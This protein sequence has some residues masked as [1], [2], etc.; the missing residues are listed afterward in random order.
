MITILGSFELFTEGPAATWDLWR[1][2][3]EEE[4]TLFGLKIEVYLCK[5][6]YDNGFEVTFVFRVKIAI[7]SCQI[8]RQNIFAN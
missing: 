7:T 4:K 6:C 3:K 2:I 5:Q 8:L 1:S